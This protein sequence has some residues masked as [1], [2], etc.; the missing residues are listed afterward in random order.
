MCCS[1]IRYHHRLTEEEEEE[2]M[3]GD[4]LNKKL[5]RRVQLLENKVKGSNSYCYD[6]PIS[7]QSIFC[8][9]FF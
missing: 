5:N 2:K 9:L 6:N 8:W 4:R 1:I 3:N 7:K